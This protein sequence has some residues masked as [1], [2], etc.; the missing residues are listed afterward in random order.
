MDG[1]QETASWADARD[2]KIDLRG[3]DRTVNRLLIAGAAA[4]HG[5]IALTD[6]VT[7]VTYADL[8][9]WA[10]RAAGSLHAAGVRPGDRVVVVSTNRLEV[11]EIFLGCSWLG[12]IFVP[13]N[14][15]SPIEQLATFLD[16]VEP[17]AILAEHTCLNPVAE[18]ART[19]GWAARRG[20]RRGDHRP[21]RR[22]QPRGVH[23]TRGVTGRGARRARQPRRGR[24]HDREGRRDDGRMVGGQ[25]ARDGITRATRGRL[26]D[27]CADP[28][29][30]RICRFA[31]GYGEQLAA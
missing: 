22:Q 31:A 15:D 5:A 3:P 18:A 20:R 28:D 8:P 26:L 7:S 29:S 4:F 27:R 6:G 25:L 23:R 17:T 24:H 1:H 14:P 19:L 21:E 9:E 10:A 11:L 2:A 12:A 30:T 13:L 16:Y